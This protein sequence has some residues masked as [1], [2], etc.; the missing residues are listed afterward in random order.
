MA[1]EPKIVNEIVTQFIE[2][3]KDG[4]KSIQ[5]MTRWTEGMTSNE[6]VANLELT[7]QNIVNGILSNQIKPNQK[8]GNHA[9]G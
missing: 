1:K 4:E 8:G 9:N 7:K 3:D 2:V 6:V 5:I